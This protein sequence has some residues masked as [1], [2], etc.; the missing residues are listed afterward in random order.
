MFL[1]GFPGRHSP[2]LY[3]LNLEFPHLD[4]LQVQLGDV[5]LGQSFGS[6]YGLTLRR[7]RDKQLGDRVGLVPPALRSLGGNIDFLLA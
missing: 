4:P 1:E 2:A 7:F 3:S 5:Q 6:F